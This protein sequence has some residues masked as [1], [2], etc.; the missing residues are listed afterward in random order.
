MINIFTYSI[1]VATHGHSTSLNIIQIIQ[2]HSYISVK[3]A[4]IIGVNEARQTKWIS[5]TEK[6]I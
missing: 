4:S 1:S 5:A 3:V 2:G 6:E